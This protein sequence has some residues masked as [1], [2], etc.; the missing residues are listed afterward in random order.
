[1]NF[2][3]QEEYRH[4]S[5]IEL[6]LITKQP[7][8]YQT[9]AVAAAADLLQQRTVTVEEM[10]EAIKLLQAAQEKEIQTY[11]A[12][13]LNQASG[14]ISDVFRALFKRNDPANATAWLKVL[15][16]VWTLQLAIPA[17]SIIYDLIL[18][19]NAELYY[20]IFN[21]FTSVII[22]FLLTG[23]Y[24]LLYRRMRWGWIL[25]FIGNIIVAVST[26]AIICNNLYF[27]FA[28]N[29]YFLIRNLFGLALSIGTCVLI[30]R[31]DI[32][33]FFKV[34]DKT[35]KICLIVGSCIGIVYAIMSLMRIS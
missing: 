1:M 27:L 34:N 33:A 31:S 18:Q 10:D 7:E 3:F 26:A 13:P 14:E 8:K 11:N 24:V 30:W 16:V 23:Y 19:M 17:A 32:A 15:M 4:L 29:S 25:C 20:R 22:L 5:N 9:G 12:N 35:R 2:D 28:A 6:L 21:L